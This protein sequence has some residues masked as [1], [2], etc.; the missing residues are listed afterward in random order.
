[1]FLFFAAA[2]GALAVNWLGLAL[3]D[4]KLE[5]QHFVY[6]VRFV[7]FLLLIGGIIDKNRRSHL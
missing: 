4:P 3:I 6:L 5:L 7:G 1:L 2:F